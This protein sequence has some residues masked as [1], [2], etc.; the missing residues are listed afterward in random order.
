MKI[1]S[2]PNITGITLGKKEHKL[3]Q[4]ADDLFLLLNGSTKSLDTTFDVFK[5][6]KRVSGLQVNVDKTHAIW[7]GSKIGSMDTVSIRI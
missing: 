1:K 6:F 2:E 4:Y 3:G 5:C 7:L